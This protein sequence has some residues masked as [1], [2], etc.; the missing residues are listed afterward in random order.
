MYI[1][2]WPSLLDYAC[3][4]SVSAVT[5]ILAKGLANSFLFL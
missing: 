4:R 1:H 5:H 2:T 3:S